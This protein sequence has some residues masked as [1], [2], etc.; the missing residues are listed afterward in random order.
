MNELQGQ[1]IFSVHRDSS[2]NI[3]EQAAISQKLQSNISIQKSVPPDKDICV[4]IA[5]SF[6]A[7][8]DDSSKEEPNEVYQGYVSEVRCC[9][10]M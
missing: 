1:R 8:I 6:K 3:K 7:L 4:P 10:H 9:R 2:S 5:N